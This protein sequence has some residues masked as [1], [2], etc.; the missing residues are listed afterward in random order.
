M[1]IPK[2][3][4]SYS[5][6]SLEH[7]KWVNDLGTRLRNNGIDA[8][9]DQWELQ[10]GDDLPHFMENHLASADRIIMICTETYVQKANKGQGGVGYEKMIIT[11]NLLKNIDT[12]KVI[13]IIRQNGSNEIPTFLET[14]LYLNFSK[15][16]DYEFNFDELIR[17]IHQSPLLKKPEVGNNPFVGNKPTL[18]EEKANDSMLEF[19]H[20]IVSK[21]EQ[22]TEQYVL[23]SHTVQQMNISRIYLDLI[24]AEAQEKGLIRLDNAGDIILT[25]KGK[26][27]AIQNDLTS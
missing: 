15:N 24:I 10:P 14:K 1:S 8:I 26:M 27:Y 9:L 13:P 20:Y 4:I 21:F 12:N 18:K 25:E 17:T 7:K 16:A 2:V 23:Y 3:F 22:T 5:H 6:D 19:M 11:S